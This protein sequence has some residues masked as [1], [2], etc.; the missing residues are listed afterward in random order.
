MAAKIGI[1]SGKSSLI[2]GVSSPGVKIGAK[3][4]T[5]MGHKS[6]RRVPGAAQG[7]AAPPALLASWWWPSFTP[8]VI[9][10]ASVALIFLS[11]F[12]GFFGALLMAGK[13]EIQ[14]QQKTAT[15]SWVPGLI[16]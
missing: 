12:P 6:V 5:E 3:G 16:D 14:K 11:D 15:G 7:G 13:P 9:P 8:L 4:G 2:L 10:E 1:A